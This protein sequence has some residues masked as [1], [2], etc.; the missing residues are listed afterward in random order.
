MVLLITQ[1]QDTFAFVTANMKHACLK[2]KQ[3]GFYVNGT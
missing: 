2:H 1:I 3:T